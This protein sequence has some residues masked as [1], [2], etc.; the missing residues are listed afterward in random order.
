MLGNALIDMYAKC[1]VVGKAQE[2]LRELH[3]RD[4][5]SWNAL[6]TGYAQYDQCNEVWSCFKQMQREGISADAVTLI[7]ILKVC[8]NTGDIDKGEVV[9]HEIMDE[10][11]LDKDI[12]IGNALVDMY[13]KC[14]VLAK[15]QNVFEILPARDV[16]SWNA[17]ISGYAENCLHRSAS[18]K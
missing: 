15:A 7:C 2:V 4:I 9:H 3:V 13:I 6:I 14:G 8:G 11:W 18:F 17:L 12:V 5:I 1:G 10:N 16:V